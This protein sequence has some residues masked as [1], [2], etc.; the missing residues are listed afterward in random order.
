MREGLFISR[1]EWNQLMKKIE[2]LEQYLINS[3]RS[4]HKSKWM[5]PA[6]AMEL[7]GCKASTL[8]KL[9]LAGAIDWRYAGNNRGVMILRSSVEQYNLSKS[10]LLER[11]R[12]DK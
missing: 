4:N 3:A 12:K 11:N 9:R 7:I 6:E 8:Q 1:V 10:T 2:F 5:K